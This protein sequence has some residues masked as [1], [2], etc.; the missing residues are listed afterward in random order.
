MGKGTMVKKTLG[1][2]IYRFLQLKDPKLT[3]QILLCSTCHDLYMQVAHELLK[4]R[5]FSSSDSFVEALG[6]VIEALSNSEKVC[7]AHFT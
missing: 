4:K 7:T 6:Y 3:S 2:K 5:P 1:L